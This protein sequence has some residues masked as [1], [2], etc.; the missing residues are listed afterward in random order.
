[1][2]QQLII[3]VKQLSTLV[4]MGI[5]FWMFT[6]IF[7][8]LLLFGPAEFWEISQRLGFSNFFHVCRNWL[9]PFFMAGYLE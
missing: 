4:K 2:D 3:G 7:V 9:R 1:M 6:V 5:L 8:Y